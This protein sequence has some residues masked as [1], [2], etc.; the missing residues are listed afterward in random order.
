MSHGIERHLT[1]ERYIWVSTN[2]SLA[3]CIYAKIKK[4]QMNRRIGPFYT[5]KLETNS[6]Q[7]RHLKPLR[8]RAG[9]WQHVNMST[10]HVTF[11]SKLRF[12]LHVSNIIDKAAR[13]LCCLKPL[14][15]HCLT[16]ESL[17]DVTRVTLIAR[18]I[19]MLPRLVRISHPGWE[20]TQIQS[21][22]LKKP[23]LRL[24]ASQFPWCL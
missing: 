1:S 17:H 3:I 23:T 15:T 4:N 12:D 14:R 11:N 19:Y 16:E 20:G 18:L 6:V 21:V 5:C 7:I 8:Q 22:I 10:D 2:T 9:S 13:V 24:P